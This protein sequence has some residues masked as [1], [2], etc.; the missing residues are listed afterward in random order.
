MTGEHRTGVPAFVGVYDRLRELIS[1]DQ[2]APG[3]ALPSDAALSGELSVSRE[4]IRE[5]LLL[6]AEDGHL[7]RQRD[8][9]WHVAEPQASTSY[10][11]PFP[12]LLSAEVT[13]V[14]RLHAAVEGGSTWSRELLGSDGPFLVWETVFAYAGVLLASTLEVMLE[15]AVPPEVLESDLW[16]VDPW[17][18]LLDS[19]DADR[20]AAMTLEQWRLTSLSRNTERL[21]WMELPM[22]G[23]PAALTIVLGEAGT[24]TYLA[25]NVFDLGTFG[26]TVHG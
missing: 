22:H 13:P 26:L 15:S 8:L 14:R 1:R 2:L 21:S 7:V 20:R 9:R 18:T 5:A 23:I 10:A 4:L 6:L 25:K 12:T 11:D 24:P 17:P 3:E 19:L 16:S